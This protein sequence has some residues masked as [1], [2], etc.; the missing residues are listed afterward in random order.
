MKRMFLAGVSALAVVATFATANAA[1]LGRRREMPVKAPMV[2]ATSYNWTGF[3]VGINGGGAWGKSDWTNPLASSS[4]FNLSG[5][6]VG[7]T[8]GYNWQVGQAVFG[9]EGDVD[10]S[11]VKGNTGALAVCGTGTCE[12]KNPWLGTFR[13]RLGYAF[14]RFMPYVTGGL[15]FGE[16]QANTPTGSVSDTRA[17]WTVG[18][19]LEAAISGPLTA[20]IEYLYTDLGSV[21]CGSPA[22]APTTD[23]DFRANLIRGGL[24][25]KF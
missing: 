9:V 20:K 3:Y 25:Y 21:S 19:G 8:A 2:V 23:A 17:G 4:D 10:W 6:M 1:D 18:A 7:G 11:G 5:G 12:T 15:A 16:L 13:G 24:N 14:D 22:C